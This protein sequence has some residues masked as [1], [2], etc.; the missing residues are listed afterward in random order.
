MTITQII[1]KKIKEQSESGSR[2]NFM[3][4]KNN[5]NIINMYKAN[6]GELLPISGAYALLT[7]SRCTAKKN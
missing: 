1:V 6:R 4:S 7:N 3:Y 5:Y 2:V